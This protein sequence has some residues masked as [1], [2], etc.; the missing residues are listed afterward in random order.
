MLQYLQATQMLMFLIQ[1]PTDA[2]LDI[3]QGAVYE[4]LPQTPRRC[5]DMLVKIDYIHQGFPAGK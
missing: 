2:S 4:K 5:T 1:C 3:S